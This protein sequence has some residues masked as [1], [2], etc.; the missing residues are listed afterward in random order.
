MK[1]SF[2]QK[3]IRGLIYTITHHA[4]FLVN[5][6]IYI[7]RK[8]K[9]N[10]SQICSMKYM[11]SLQYSSPFISTEIWAEETGSF[12]AKLA[13]SSPQFDETSSVTGIQSFIH[14]LEAIKV[15]GHL[16]W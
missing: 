16:P 8:S 12:E 4:T 15:H 10:T 6:C 11:G 7:Q 2:L 5:K 14:E 9:L 3:Y 1:I 13:H